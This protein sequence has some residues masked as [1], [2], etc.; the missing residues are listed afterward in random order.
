MAVL[1]RL[2]RTED[3]PPDGNIDSWE[4]LGLIEELA[5]NQNPSTVAGLIRTLK[6]EDGGRSESVRLGAACALLKLGSHIPSGELEQL[7]ESENSPLVKDCLMS[8][9][10]LVGTARG[11]A[12]P[13][14]VVEADKTGLG[15]D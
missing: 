11:R 15:G 4:G 10:E 1:D 6:N 7:I 5:G 13:G 12:E 8:L 3:I 2:S 9:S 14:E